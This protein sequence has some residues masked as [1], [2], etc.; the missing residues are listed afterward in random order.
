MGEHQSLEQTKSPPRTDD[1]RIN[2]LLA[3]KPSQLL[4]AHF[5]PYPS[6]LAVN[7]LEQRG[8]AFRQIVDE[9]LHKLGAAV[10]ILG[11]RV[12]DVLSW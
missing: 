4:V 2:T 10:V 5:I 6:S 12:D 11:Q 3:R 9:D 1:Q 7:R 8:V